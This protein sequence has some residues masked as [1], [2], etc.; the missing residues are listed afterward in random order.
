MSSVAEITSAIRELTPAER[1]ELL[2]RIAEM[3]RAEGIPLPSPRDLSVEQMQRWIDED[4]REMREI[5]EGR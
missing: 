5:R 4:E 3:I 1:S 2:L